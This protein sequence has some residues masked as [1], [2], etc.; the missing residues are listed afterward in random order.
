MKQNTWIIHLISNN[1]LGVCQ[2]N[3]HLRKAAAAAELQPPPD[4][5]F[6]QFCM[7]LIGLFKETERGNRYFIVLTDYLTKWPEAEA[8]PDKQATTIADFLIKII[9]RY[10]STEV[11]IID[12]GR[13]RVNDEICSRMGI[14]H[15]KTS[16]YHPQ[17]NGLTERYNQTLIYTLVKYTN[18]EQDD[19]DMLNLLCWPTVLQNTRV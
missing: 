9:C 6:K 10:A 14:D 1:M 13:N 15:R 17:S 18:E 3:N 2:A 11:L 12:Q 7:D 8:I 16:A 19:W 4:G 5:S